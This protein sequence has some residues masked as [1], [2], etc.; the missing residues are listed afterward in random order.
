[1]GGDLQSNIAMEEKIVTR[2]QKILSEELN[3][4]ISKIPQMWCLYKE[5]QEYYERGMNVPDNVTLLWSDDNWGNLRRL[6]ST[7]ERKR[8]GGTGIYY[9]ADYVGGPRSYKWINT[10]PIPKI[11]D[12]MN[13]AYEYGANRIWIMNVGDLKPLEIP[14]D[15][16]LQMAWNPRTFNQD[17]LSDY[18]LQWAKTQFGLSQASEIAN[19]VDQYTKYNGWIKPELLS[20]NTFSLTNYREAETVINKWENLTKLAEAIY[21]TLPDEKKDAFFEL[22]LYPVKASYIVNNLY[23][24]VAK[25]RF[26]AQQGRISI[27]DYA[28]KARAL[29][30][31]DS[32]LTETYHKQIAHG[33][34]DGI[35]TQPHIGYTGWKDPAHNIM[36]KLESISCSTPNSVGLTIE[37]DTIT[38]PVGKQITLPQFSNY[39]RDKHYFELFATK[40]GN[41]EFTIKPLQSWI[42][43]S[44]KKGILQKEKR[45]EVSIDWSKAPKGK[46]VTGSI[47]VKYGKRSFNLA[48]LAFN[49]LLPE[50]KSLKGFVESN[51][52]IAMEAEHYSRNKAVN[53]VQW[54]RIPNYG[55]TLSSM[56]P[57]PV[58]APVFTNP[59]NAPTLEYECYLFSTGKVEIN[60]LIAPTL[61]CLPDGDMRFAIAIDDEQPQIVNIPRISI[62]GVRDN[63]AWNQSVIDNIRVCKTT[64]EINKAGYHT[65]K[66]FMIDPIVTIQR[67][68][69]N[70]GGLKSSFFYP[71]E[72]FHRQ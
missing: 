72:S 4:D 10:L 21:S 34:W 45:I 18:T 11:W 32:L 56:M 13:K 8:S 71:P 41:Y 22:V 17:N 3:P 52:Y 57:I 31:Q 46:N 33:K 1:M 58:T 30:V 5:I 16:F 7:E 15:F 23:F 62:N 67:L 27:Q 61:N 64:H 55:K 69:V 68:V 39:S 70:T 35:M 47:D 12:Q 40:T 43:V 20:P 25:N 54:Q 2:Q 6:P 38:T 42:I 66:I 26:Y 37:G 65:I 60:T 53:G 48:I 29:F 36:P 28:T 14:I 50:R 63:E 9:H 51:G 49:P 44:V 59:K 19:I 24:N